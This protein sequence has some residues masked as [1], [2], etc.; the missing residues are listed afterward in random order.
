MKFFFFIIL[1]GFLA[2][3]SLARDSFPE[4][5]IILLSFDGTR[6]DALT[7][8]NAPHF[9][10]LAREGW[11][12]SLTPIFPSETFPNHATL[13][14]GATA[15]QHG[16]VSN[17]FI[18][19]E[20]GEF[21]YSMD[22]S[23]L[24]CKPLWA[25]L[26]EHDIP[27]ATVAW[28][29][30]GRGRWHGQEPTYYESV[31]TTDIKKIIHF[32]DQKK[33]QKIVTLLKLPKKERPHFIAAWF[34]NI[35]TQ[36][37]AF[38]PKASQVNEAIKY[39]D[40]LLGNF[41]RALQQVPNKNNIDLLI[42]SDHGMS[43]VKTGISVPY[44]QHSLIAMGPVKIIESGSNARLYCSAEVSSKILPFLKKLSH[45]T[46]AFDVYKAAQLPLTWR[47]RD[48]RNGQLLLVARPGYY[49]EPNSQGQGKAL[50]LL[51]DQRHHPMGKHG[52]PPS[53]SEMKALFIAHGPDFS[54]GKKVQ[55]PMTA[56]APFVLR[57]LEI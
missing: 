53:L 30:H 45:Q 9:L 15:E 2:N 55:L 18:D 40:Q 23:W 5:T 32:D 34:P 1:F 24:L 19:P 31:P 43:L 36:E 51:I 29:L 47:D 12:G 3:S 26:E 16:I 20:R 11:Q 17:K 28:P 50:S 41:L 35:D 10:Q 33:F 39:Y 38:G 8:K 14:T 22:P 49:F 25:T 4:R 7:G 44:L 27:T 37:H 57:L 21:A 6:A 42:V 13:M 52:Y 46:H 54:P 56:I 48:I